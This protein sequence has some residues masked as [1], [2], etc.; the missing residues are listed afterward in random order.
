M[1][2]SNVPSLMVPATGAAAS[3]ERCWPVGAFQY[4]EAYLIPAP[5][6]VAVM[7]TLT[8]LL[9]LDVS[10]LV[11]RIVK[12]VSTGSVASACP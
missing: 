11:S 1:T 12:P 8:V 3:P 10:M 7:R 9:S 6:S 5:E 4:T 2:A